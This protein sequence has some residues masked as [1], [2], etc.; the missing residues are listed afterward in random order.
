MFIG[1]LYI[2]HMMRYFY[3]LLDSHNH[4]T[5]ISAPMYCFILMYLKYSNHLLSLFDIN[6]SAY[7]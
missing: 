7:I 2:A 6:F 3:G 1:L 4:D 5:Y